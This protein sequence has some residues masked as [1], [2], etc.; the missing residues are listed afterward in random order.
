MKPRKL[1]V[2]PLESRQMM[3]AWSPG[4]RISD[5]TVDEGGIATL[6][7]T[8]DNTS[9]LTGSV[10]WA[11][12]SDSAGSSD[13]TRAS[14]T[15]T[16]GRNELS[17]TIQIRT[18]EDTLVEGLESFVV[19]LSSAKYGTIK[20][21]KGVVTIR[22]NDSAAP[23]TPTAPAAPS[24]LTATA[25][26]DASI[27]LNWTD[28]SNNETGFQIER[29][30]IGTDWK[31]VGTATGTTFTNT[32]LTAETSYSYRVRAVNA[33]GGSGYTL[34]ATATTEAGPV[35]PPPTP[36]GDIG[37][38]GPI[39]QQQGVVAP[40]GAIILSASSSISSIHSTINNAAAGA[41]FFLKAGTYRDFSVTPKAGQTF[42][43]EYGAI[44]TSSSKAFAFGPNDGTA[45]Q[46]ITLKNL[47][48]DGYN[49]GYQGC[50]IEAADYWTIDFCEVRNSSDG[51]VFLQSHNRLTNSWVHDAGVIGVRAVDTDSNV[52]SCSDVL[53]Q[54]TRISNCNKQ[55]DLNEA[56]GS[57]FWNVDGLRV[58]NCEWDHNRGDGIWGDGSIEGG[59]G[60]RN[61][62]I[63]YNWVH[64]NTRYGIY[65]ET[66]GKFWVHHNI[67]ERNGDGRDGAGIYVNM[68]ED[69]L[70][71][72]NI[73]RGNHNGIS[74]VSIDRDT[75]RRLRNITIRNN[76]ISWLGGSNGV[77]HVG[78]L[79]YFNPYADSA[80]INWDF[81]TYRMTA[82]NSNSFDWNGSWGSWSRWQA[83]GNDVH[84]TLLT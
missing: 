4:I 3:A 64:D 30:V 75:N 61:V 13:F 32:G 74:M 11:T 71:E 8:R 49:S 57:K 36:T 76:E 15:I 25:L 82:S 73:L 42:V 1:N 60:N 68:S 41:T 34:V 9:Y 2:E 27:R 65:Q 31:Q 19:N 62:E 47:V 72:N 20:D 7:V 10:K 40:A 22:D 46:R 59:G 44:L 16:F 39:G 54:N 48:I 26:G 67:S 6:T 38:T 35:D 45:S 28:N 33:V 53:V 23:P 81:N 63:A 50:A 79:S 58:I 66:G 14:G 78:S 43:G 29:S 51:A 56:G 70:I 37:L 80:N 21:G 5:A 24:S 55:N 12:A 52:T 17:K 83:A 77:Y 18:K 84:G 69:G